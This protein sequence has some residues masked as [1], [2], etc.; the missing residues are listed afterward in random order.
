MT[1]KSIK[2]RGRLPTRKKKQYQRY[3][4]LKQAAWPQPRKAT[5]YSRPFPYNFSSSLSK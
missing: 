1:N 3:P 4:K 5:H 2:A